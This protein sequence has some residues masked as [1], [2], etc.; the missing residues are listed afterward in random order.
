LGGNALTVLISCISSCEADFEETNSTLKYANRYAQC[1]AEIDEGL[2][3][4]HIH[5][6]VAGPTDWQPEACKTAQH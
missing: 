1:C 3:V 5:T 4:V 2:M 6:A